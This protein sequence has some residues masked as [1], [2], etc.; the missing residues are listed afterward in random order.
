MTEA[1]PDEFV[2]AI[3]LVPL[4]VPLESEP[5]DVVRRMP[6]PDAEPPDRP[7]DKVTVSGCDRAVPA[8]PD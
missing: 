7:G 8:L 5:A 1:A 2:V 3:R 4:V 6:V